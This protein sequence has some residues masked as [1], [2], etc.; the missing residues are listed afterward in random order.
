MKKQTFT[1]TRKAMRPMSKKCECFYCDQPIGAMH[2]DDCTLIRKRVMI[3]MV[4]EYPIDV[5]RHWTKEMVEH[6]RNGSTW[7]AD[8]ALDELHKECKVSG[9]LCQHTK[10]TQ[11][12]DMKCVHLSE[13]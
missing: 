1:V 4:V 13:E 12:R 8:N 3:R 10:F 2:K 6:H 7:C 5:P 9:C 11:V